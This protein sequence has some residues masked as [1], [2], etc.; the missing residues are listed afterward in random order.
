M[1]QS[2]IDKLEKYRPKLAMWI[3]DQTCHLDGTAKQDILNIIREEFE[4]MYHVDMWCGPCVVK[5]LVFAFKRMDEW[6]ERE[7]YKN[8]G[9]KE[10]NEIIAIHTILPQTDI[11]KGYNPEG[12]TEIITVIKKKKKWR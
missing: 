12:K 5:M 8:K 2:N 7:Y 3:N 9:L 6:I 1:N 11:P 10:A 4:P